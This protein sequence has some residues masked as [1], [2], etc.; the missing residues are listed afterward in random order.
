MLLR[1]RYVMRLFK[2]RFDLFALLEWTAAIGFLFALTAGAGGTV[3]WTTDFASLP[4]D[5]SALQ[6]WLSEQN[7]RDVRVIREENS[8]ALERNRTSMFD[9][10]DFN[11]MPKPPWTELGYPA[12]QGMHGSFEWHA[13]SGSPFVWISGFTVIIL[14]H[15]IRRRYVEPAGDR[16]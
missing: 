15:W 16:T 9:Q 12:P 10:V 7:R 11:T 3:S 4:I 2:P 1:L 6:A 5:D 13:F 14:L 8:I